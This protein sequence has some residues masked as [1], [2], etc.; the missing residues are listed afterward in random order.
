MNESNHGLVTNRIKSFLACLLDIRDEL[1][2][3]NFGSKRIGGIFFLDLI[4]VV[5]NKS[6]I[7]FELDHHGLIIV[8]H[9]SSLDL[10]LLTLF[11][12]SVFAE[13]CL[14]SEVRSY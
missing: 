13:R 3:I 10:F 8:I 7:V 12:V 2:K 4:L 1:F 6:E 5:G 11:D 14:A 9:P